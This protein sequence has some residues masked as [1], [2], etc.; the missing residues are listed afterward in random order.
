MIVDQIKE[1]LH[2]GFHP[3][4]VRLS[5]GRA[6]PVPHRDFI[7]VHPR[8]VVVIDQNGISHTISPLHIVS[9]GEETQKD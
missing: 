6:F 3:F 9:I 1:R 8:V 7:A 5:D 2:N 4:T